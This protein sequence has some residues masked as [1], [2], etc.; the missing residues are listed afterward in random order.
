ML[1]CGRTDVCSVS[2]AAAV[3]ACWL[4]PAHYTHHTHTLQTLPAH[5]EASGCPAGSARTP[6]WH[7]KCRLNCR[8]WG[9]PCIFIKC[10]FQAKQIYSQAGIKTGAAVLSVS[11]GG[12]GLVY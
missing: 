3:Q 10:A 9:K 7:L 2:V 5:T 1:C 4:C 12:L 11:Q 8:V 6:S